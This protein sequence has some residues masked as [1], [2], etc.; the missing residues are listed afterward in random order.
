VALREDA[1][2]G[3]L[4]AAEVPGRLQLIAD[5]PPT[6][7]DGAHNPDAVAA[8]VRGLDEALPARPRALVLGVLEDKDAAGMLAL[9]LGHFDRAW[10]TAPPGERALPPAALVEHARRLGFGEVESEPRPRAAL[11]QASAW[12]LE[13]GGSVLATG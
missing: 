9:L 4:A 12:A 5:E 10:F 13:R 7:L 8:L 3:A 11:A 1:V 6:L 2:R